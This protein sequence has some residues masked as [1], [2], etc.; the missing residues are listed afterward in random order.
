MLG[1]NIYT[2]LEHISSDVLKMEHGVRVI[3]PVEKSPFL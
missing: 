3:D 1:M 2:S